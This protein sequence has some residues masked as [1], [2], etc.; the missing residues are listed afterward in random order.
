MRVRTRT[1]SGVLK[2]Y[3]CGASF[4]ADGWAIHW[5]NAGSMLVHHL[6]RWPNS[7]PALGQCILFAGIYFQSNFPL[8]PLPHT[9]WHKVTH[10]RPTLDVGWLT[11]PLIYS[12]INHADQIPMLWVYGQYRYFTLS[13]RGSTLDDVYRRQIQTSIVGPNHYIEINSPTKPMLPTLKQLR[14]LLRSSY[15]PTPHFITRAAFNVLE[16]GAQPHLVHL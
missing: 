13:V 15:E 4:L 14:R 9:Q 5:P 16:T 3:R 12:C 2:A 6:W 10:N 11:L 7:E 8:A 1:I